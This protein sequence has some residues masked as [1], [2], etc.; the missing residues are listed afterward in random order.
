[1]TTEDGPHYVSIA[2]TV[3]Q[4]SVPVTGVTV[5]APSLPNGSKPGEI[6]QLTATVAPENATNKTVTWRSSDSTVATV[7]S[8]GLVTVVGNGMATITATTT[9][10]N[11]VHSFTFQAAYAPLQGPFTV[12]IENERPEGYRDGQTFN[13]KVEGNS[14]N[15]IYGIQVKVPRSLYNANDENGHVNLLQAA[16]MK[17]ASDVFTASDSVST[18]HKTDYHH[19][20]AAQFESGGNRSV[21]ASKVFAKLPFRVESY[22]IEDD[23]TFTVKVMIV[24]KNGN[25][26]VEQH[27][28]MTIHALLNPIG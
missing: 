22:N 9:D 2:V 11:F 6:I 19:V 4:Q 12:S 20:Y 14:L 5:T 24:D 17:A 21:T 28:P 26:V 13:L 10:S 8:S 1:V 15:D 25:V 7:D 18:F 23:I 27:I 16:G 3:V